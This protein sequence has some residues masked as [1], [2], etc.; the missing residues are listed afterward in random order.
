[1]SENRLP[2]QVF[3]GQLEHGTRL[4]GGQQKRCKDM[5]KSNLKARNIA[6]YQLETLSQ[7]RMI[8]VAYTVHSLC[9]AV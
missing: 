7:D 2:K 8:F 1:M 5:L 4:H 3:Y 9:A 6:P